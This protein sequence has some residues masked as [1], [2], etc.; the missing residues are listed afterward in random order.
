MSLSRVVFSSAVNTWGTPDELYASLDRLIG[1]TL[2]ACAL[3]KT[4]KTKRFVGPNENGLNVSWDGERI[5]N[6]P[7]YDDAE[8][9]VPKARNE[10]LEGTCVSGN[11]LPWRGDTEWWST[12]VLSEDGEAGRL[13][14]SWY[15]DKNRMLWL[16][17]QRIWTGIHQFDGRIT[18]DGKTKSGKPN[19]APFPSALII[20]ATP[21]LQPKRRE[22]ITQMWPRG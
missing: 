13:R 16:K 14:E 20:H 3:P 19:N 11:L 5:W 8:S 12:G 4:A 10:S 2:D 18:F 6:N 17:R 7:P 1:F 21:G 15:D 9:W 22:G